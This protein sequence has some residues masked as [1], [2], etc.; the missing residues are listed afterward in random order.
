MPAADGERLRGHVGREVTIGIRPED[1]HVA[2]DADPVGLTFTVVEVVE[3]LGSEILLDVRVGTDMMVASRR[4]HRARQGGRPAA[5]RR[6]P[7]APALLRREDRG[8]DLGRR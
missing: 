6:Q 1:L 2:T 5:A 7:G 4:S 3:Q 8:G